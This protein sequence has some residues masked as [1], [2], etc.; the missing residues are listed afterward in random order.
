M[1][2]VQSASNPPSSAHRAPARATALAARVAGLALAC[3]LLAGCGTV[4]GWFGGGKD[5]TAPAPL[6]EFA[7]TAQPALLWSARAGKGEGRIGAGQGPAIA[8][9][10]VFAAAVHGGVHAFDLETGAPAWHAPSDLRLSGGPGVGDGLVVAGGLDGDVLALDAATGAERWRAKVGNEVIAAPAIGQGL[11]LVRS[12]DG[13]LTAFDA[14]TG[15]RRWFWSG[16][17]PALTVRG[18]GAPLLVPGL[19]IV[20][21]DGGGLVA[22]ALQD[23]RALWDQQVAQPEG[24]TDL[25]RMADVDGT[26]VLDGVT[27]FASSYKGQTIAVDG[28]NGQPLWVR[29]SG[30]AGQIGDGGDRIVL[31]DPQGT[32]W[33]LDKA[34]GSALWQQP[35][36]ARRRP[37]GAA[38]HAGHAVV[39]D[40]DGY[41]HWL[42]LTDGEFAARTR[43]G[44]AAIR[45]A[46][47]V[48]GDVLVVQDIDGRLSAYRLR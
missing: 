37:G 38:V 14:A 13:R 34:G 23:G 12:N 30:G 48:S 25:E 40:Y 10:R 44:K 45:S 21:T 35:G 9:G 33:A 1:N 22:V 6:V 28:R 32:V 5:A 41:L 8:D 16:D 2:P 18:N 39:G 19:A 4:R 17:L 24:R 26:P 20:G 11:V 42:R 15:Q 29:D 43:V 3:V 31:A 7:A 46:P 27:V 47:R 36:L